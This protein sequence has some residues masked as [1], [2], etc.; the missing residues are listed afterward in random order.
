[1]SSTATE[2]GRRLYVGGLN[3]DTDERTLREAFDKFGS[4]EEGE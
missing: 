1:M 4:I 2:E 3:Y